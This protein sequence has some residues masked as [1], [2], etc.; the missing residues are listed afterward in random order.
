MDRHF[1]LVDAK[2]AE[3]NFFLQQLAG[4]EANFFTARC[5]FSPFLSSARSITFALQAVMSGVDGF[6]EW[7]KNHQ[8]ILF[9]LI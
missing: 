7:Y 5:Y 6:L 2:V 4:S 9:V 1:G 3:A 8:A